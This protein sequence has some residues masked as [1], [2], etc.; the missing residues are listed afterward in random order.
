MQWIAGRVAILF[1]GHACW[2][3]SGDWYCRMVAGVSLISSPHNTTVFLSECSN[4]TTATSTLLL[5]ELHWMFSI[6]PP[7]L[8][9]VNGSF[10]WRRNLQMISDL[11]LAW[12]N[13]KNCKL[14]S[15]HGIILFMIWLHETLV[16]LRRSISVNMKVC[17]GLITGRMLSTEIQ[18]IT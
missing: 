3:L 12:R 1:Q 5:H 2:C 18:M 7:P 6:F 13:L 11:I 16:R 9:H 8:F 4:R 17:W 10:Q 15:S 14:W